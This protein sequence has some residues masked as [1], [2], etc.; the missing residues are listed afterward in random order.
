MNK[1]FLLLIFSLFLSGCVDPVV[2]DDTPYWNEDFPNFI[3]FPSR[4][5]AIASRGV[6]EGE[7]MADRLNDFK[8]LE[9]ERE[10]IT[11]RDQALREKAFP[12]TE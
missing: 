12:S 3:G 1:N 8:K 5:A 10:Q 4:C 11:A 9:Q 7:E 2:W 6:H